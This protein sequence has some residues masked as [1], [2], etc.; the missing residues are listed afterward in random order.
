MKLSRRCK[1]RADW[2]RR[3]Q[4][5]HFSA[6]KEDRGWLRGNNWGMK[7]EHQGNAAHIFATEFWI[8]I[9]SSI[10]LPPPVNSQHRGK[11]DF[12]LSPKSDHVTSL[13]KTLLQLSISLRAKAEVLLLAYRAHAI[14]YCYLPTSPPTVLSLRSSHTGPCT[15]LSQGLALV[16]LLKWPSLRYHMMNFLTRSES[17]LSCHPPNET[18]PDHPI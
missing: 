1:Q 13:L 15:L 7:I 18:D 6:R 3:G 11:S 2:Q 5:S 4:A 8:Q 9:L 16:F 17:F 14:R 12:F 10:L